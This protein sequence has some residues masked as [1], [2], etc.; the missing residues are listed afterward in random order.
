MFVYRLILDFGLLIL[1]W[2]V[3]LIIYPS[4]TYLSEYNFKV[5]HKKYTFLI[6]LFVLPLMIGQLAIL[7]GQIIFQ[8]SFFTLFSIALVAVAWISTF[9][10]AMPLHDE[11]DKN[12]ES[13]SYRN[14]LIRINWVRTFSWTLVFILGLV[15]H[16]VN[17]T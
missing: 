11:M 17:H 9:M 14:T 16:S 5:W 3:Q 7:F 10:Q 8:F 12:P 6:S 1:I 2:L 13:N 15:E 4:F